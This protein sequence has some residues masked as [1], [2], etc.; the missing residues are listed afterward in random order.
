MKKA[1]AILIMLLVGALACRMPGPIESISSN[2][3]AERST[4]DGWIALAEEQDVFLSATGNEKYAAMA[5]NK[6]GEYLVVLTESRGEDTRVVGAVW[7]SSVTGDSIVVHLSDVGLPETMVVGETIF[8][9]ENYQDGLV[10]IVVIDA[11]GQIETFEKVPFDTQTSNRNNSLTSLHSVS[12]FV[13]QA[14]KDEIFVWM[15]VGSIAITT[16]SCAGF[17]AGM[18]PLGLAC[19]SLFLKFV[20]VH[21]DYSIPQELGAVIGSYGC[22][23]ELDPWD[24]VDTVLDLAVYFE[25]KSREYI[26][27]HQELIS[28]IRGFPGNQFA[29]VYDGDI[30]LATA[31]GDEV[32]AITS[33]G[34]FRKIQ[35]SPFGDFILGFTEGHEIYLVNT[36]TRGT[37]YLGRT[38]SYKPELV[39]I[40]WN[41]DKNLLLLTDW[42]ERRHKIFNLSDFQS[43]DVAS[44]SFYPHT[45][46]FWLDDEYLYFFAFDGFGRMDIYGQN[47]ELLINWRYFFDI[48]YVSK[49]SGWVAVWS[50]ESEGFGH[51]A[52]VDSRGEILKLSQNDY[53][54][55]EIVGLPS[56]D[57][58]GDWNPAGTMFAYQ[59]AN[60][61]WGNTPDEIRIVD[62]NKSLLLETESIGVNPRWSKDGE[63]LAYVRPNG[64]LGILSYEDIVASFRDSQFDLYDRRVIAVSI[65]NNLLEQYTTLPGTG[66]Q[67]EF[68]GYWADE[69]FVPHWNNDGMAMILETPGGYVYVDFAGG[70]SDWFPDRLS[71]AWRPASSNQ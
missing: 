19:A 66:G 25:E 7:G 30:W 63:Q 47:A 50:N 9:F 28:S 10:D 67:V 35:W 54:F 14:E 55:G 13:L 21:T 52:F 32:L 40:A 29:F 20:E 51:L 27:Q 69:E 17:V 49:S 37:L 36:S 71:P 18:A 45:S 12:N 26:N 57:Q 60:M 16:A 41:N 59:P 22:L 48:R 43:I 34:S 44:E 65:P 68:L 4:G 5:A 58:G 46:P 39:D 33:G 62:V 24:C 53:R 3:S 15:E 2:T 38:Q 11:V 64:S 31:E 61:W 6:E 8:I 56:G 1:K 42:E 70:V 23:M